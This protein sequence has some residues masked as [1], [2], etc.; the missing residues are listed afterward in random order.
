MAGYVL[1]KQ[2]WWGLLIAGYLFLGG[3]GGMMTIASSYWWIRYRNKV[4]AF[5][6]S[7]SAL[8]AMAIGI[9][10]LVLD[11]TKP[12]SAPLIYISPRVNLGSWVAIGTYIITGYTLLLAFFVA[13]FFPGIRRLPWHRLKRVLDR[14]ILLAAVFGVATASY[15]GF[16]LSSAPGVPFWNTPLLPLLFVVSGLSTGFCVYCLL[17]GPINYLMNKNGG[18]EARVRLWMQRIDVTALAAELLVVSII[19]YSA[20]LSGHPAAIESAKT[21]LYGRLAPVFWGLV[22]VAG[23]L[24]PMTIMLAYTLRVEAEDLRIVVVSAVVAALVLIGGFA[25]RYTILEAGYVMVPLG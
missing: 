25:L 7:L 24:A 4:V 17:L 18:G 12:L 21:I 23:I 3:L 6:G 9:G 19:L 8:V 14:A 2:E 22:V 5:F 13:Q 20:L 16:L 10:L 15:T 11:L 1:I